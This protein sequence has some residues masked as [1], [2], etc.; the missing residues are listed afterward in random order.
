MHTIIEPEDWFFT[1]LKI[2]FVIAVMTLPFFGGGGDRKL[3]MGLTLLQG[4]NVGV[5]CFVVGAALTGVRVLLRNKYYTKSWLPYGFKG[6]SDTEVNM[7]PG[8]L[9]AYIIIVIWRTMV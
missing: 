2:C 5:F 1:L 3:I 7:A 4:F 6:E 9:I 8:I